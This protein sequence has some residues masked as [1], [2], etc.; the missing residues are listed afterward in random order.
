MNDLSE[1]YLENPDKK[2]E[3]ILLIVSKIIY[4]NRHN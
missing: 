3:G 1:E 4:L 2:V